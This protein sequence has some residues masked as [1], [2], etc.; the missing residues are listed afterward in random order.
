[1][2]YRGALGAVIVVDCTN[3]DPAYVDVSI[4]S[5]LSLSLPSSPDHWAS[6][7]RRQTHHSPSLPHSTAP[8]E[9]DWYKSICAHATP[10]VKYA[11]AVAVNK[12]D[13]SPREEVIAKLR[14]EVQR[15][16]QVGGVDVT[17][18]LTSAVT[19]EG[20]TEMFTD[21]AARVVRHKK[22]ST[23]T[24][25][26]QL[27]AATTTAAATTSINAHSYRSTTTTTTTLQ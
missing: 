21:V 11:I 19:G 20:V 17:F 2:Y 24:N 10:S 3:P 23:D 25:C 16:G 14:E 22:R 26:T 8:T 18:H 13:Q 5:K 15:L 27:P 1:M 9:I 6:S 4:E 12:C 7:R